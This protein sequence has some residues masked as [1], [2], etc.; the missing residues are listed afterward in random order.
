MSVDEGPSNIGDI[1]HRTG[2]RPTL[3]AKYRTRLLAAGLIESTEHGKVAFAIPGLGQYLRKNPLQ[4]C[5]P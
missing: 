4:I 5:G 3:V 1:V 2:S